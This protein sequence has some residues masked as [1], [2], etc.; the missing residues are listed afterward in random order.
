MARIR[1]IKP[2]F[3]TN[4]QL[5][6]LEP[7]TADHVAAEFANF[8]KSRCGFQRHAHRKHD[9]AA[10]HTRSGRCR[11]RGIDSFCDLPR[12]DRLGLVMK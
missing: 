9:S 7:L 12:P 2:S 11:N 5:A 1:T 10:I 6:D 4:E 3:F 8:L